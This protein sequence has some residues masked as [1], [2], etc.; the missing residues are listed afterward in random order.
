M[1]TLSRRDFHRRLVP[2][3]CPDTSYLEQPGFEDRLQQYRRG[4]FDYVGVRAAVQLPIP[5]GADR[6]LVKIESP[7]LWGVESDSD[8]NYLDSVFREECDTLAD[9]LAEL[10]VKVVD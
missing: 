2:D 3:D 4:D 10:G 8:E 7:G 1:I 5:Y 6:I 9:M